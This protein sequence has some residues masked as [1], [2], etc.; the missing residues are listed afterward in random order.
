MNRWNSLRLVLFI[1]RLIGLLGI[2]FIIWELLVTT[3]TL[4]EFFI[5][6]PI[7]VMEAVF[8]IIMTGKYSEHV[9]LT[10]Q[11]F[12]L[13]LLL[14]SVFGL[15]IG[16]MIGEFW[17]LRSFFMLYIFII[18]AIPKILFY[19]IIFKIFVQ[20]FWFKVAFVALHAFIFVIIGVVSTLKNLDVSLMIMAKTYGCTGFRLYSKIFWPAAYFSLLASLRMATISSLVGAIVADMLIAPGVGYVVNQLAY[21]FMVSELYALIAVVALFAIAIN[22]ALLKIEKRSVK[23]LRI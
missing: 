21:R 9:F 13:G 6:R 8:G 1:G 17:F 2:F 5:P 15:F 16:L 20:P 3:N 10:L 4:N 12:V 23:L 18:A 22:F 11:T 19:P 14:G 7:R